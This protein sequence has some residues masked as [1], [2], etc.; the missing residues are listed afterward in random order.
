MEI[1][2]SSINLPLR[3]CRCYQQVRAYL[4]QNP[5]ERKNLAHICVSFVTQRGRAHT[6]IKGFSE[7]DL[8]GIWVIKKSLPKKGSFGGSFLLSYQSPLPK[9]RR[10]VYN[11]CQRFY[12][13]GG[14]E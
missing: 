7:L 2:S 6:E 12:F 11:D 5:G 13:K 14:K 3:T 4:N 10:F 9:I 1:F 8:Q